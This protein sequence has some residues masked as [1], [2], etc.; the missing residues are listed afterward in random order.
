MSWA[1]KRSDPCP[2]EAMTGMIHPHIGASIKS[3]DRTPRSRE[4]AGRLP[5]CR[6][7]RPITQPY[8]HSIHCGVCG[9]SF[10]L[11]VHLEITI[12]FV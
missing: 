5:A 7:S 3:I 10:F 2:E 11:E 9:Y 12:R 4:M 8:H 6:T 1:F